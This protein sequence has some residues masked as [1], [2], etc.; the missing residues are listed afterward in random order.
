MASK[1]GDFQ[2]YC[3][4]FSFITNGKHFSSIFDYFDV[5][6]LVKIYGEIFKMVGACW[7]TL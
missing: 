3:N 5:N 1:W 4:L 6:L 7:D 2:Q